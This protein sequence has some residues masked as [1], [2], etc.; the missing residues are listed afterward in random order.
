MKNKFILFLNIVTLLSFPKYN[1]GQTPDLGTT[2]GFALFTAVG[3]F[4]N[5]GTSI[6]TGD[7][8]SNTYTPTGFPVPGTVVGNIYHAGDAVSIQA[9]TDVNN[10]YG[11]LSTLGGT[12][13]GVTI[14][15]NQV[16]TP[17]VWST[18][19]ASTLNGTVIIDGMG[20]P[21]SLFIIR[22][23]GAFATGNSSNIV[24]I[25]SASICN[26]YWQ[27]NGEFNLGNSSVFRGTVIANGA[28][29]LLENSTLFGRALSKGGA[30]SLNN[31]IVNL[32]AQTILS[33][34]Y[35]NGLTSI[36]SGDSIVLSGNNGGIWSTGAT[37]PTIT[38]S[39]SGDYYLI[40]SNACGNVTSNHILVSVNPLPTI[41]AISASG[42]SV[43]CIGDSVILSGNN[44][45]IW[46]NGASTP[47]ITVNTNGDYFVTN[48]NACGS[49]TSNHITVSINPIPIATLIQANCI[50]STAT[51][52]FT[53]PIGSGISYSINDL[54]YFNTTGVFNLVSSGVYHLSAKY[55]GGC[56]SSGADVI[57][58]AR[59]VTPSA[60]SVSVLQPTCTLATG[61]AVLGGLPIGNWTINPGLIMG[62]TSSFTI[63]VLSALTISNYTVT[64]SD[65][66]T[67][68]PTENIIINAQPLSPIVS[69]TNPNAVF[70]PT[71]VNLTATAITIG[72]TPGLTYSYWKDALATLPYESPLTAIAGIYY[73]KG[74]TIAG[75]FAI[76]PVTV[77]INPEIGSGCDSIVYVANNYDNGIG[78]LR[79]AIANVCNNGTVFF[80]S[81]IDGQTINLTSGTLVIDKNIKFDN[82]NHIS[83]I[84]ISGI[85][86]NLTI[87]TGN[88]LTL[89]SG[90]K[91]TVT[92]VITSH[93][94]ISGLLIVSGA[95]F[96]YYLCELP[97]T[98]Q[99]LLTS[100]WH[101]FGSPF[102]PNMGA[103]LSNITSSVGSTQLKP[104]IN[105]VN[106]SNNITSPYYF[107]QPSVGYAI[108]PSST[109]TAVLNG[110]LFCNPCNPCPCD[111]IIPLIY[112]GS[113][114]TQSWNLLSNP[115][116]SYINWNLV[117]KINVSNT[118][119]LWDNNL[120]PAMNP[121]ANSAY[122]RTYNSNTNIGV[123]AGTQSYI[124]PMQGFFVKAVY[125]NPKIMIPR[126]ARTNNSSVYYKDITTTEIL[127]RLKIETETGY[128][129]LV[130]CKNQESELNFEAFDSEKFFNNLPVEIYSQS[131]TGEKLTINTINTTN[132][133]IPVGMNG[134]EGAKAKITAFALESGEQ[135][136]LED[137]FKGKIISL[138]DQR[139]YEFEFPTNAINE[140]FFI[141]FGNI[142]APLSKSVINVFENNNQLNIIAQTGE[143]LKEVEI[144]TLT[145]KSVFNSKIANSNLFSSE[146]N[147]AQAMY[148]V[149][150]KTSLSTQNIKISWK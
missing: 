138:T 80:L 8:G 14:V 102:M 1:F 18:G 21:N 89:E 109:F 38:V 120:Y 10:L 83:G 37:T 144:F 127:L 71:T 22:I 141:H 103:S 91:I 61:S 19:A 77:I 145:G 44:G 6:I 75:C 150:V 123:P 88:T 39:T 72:S 79:N 131:T 60:P 114:A 112:N 81:A 9:A 28:I 53:S 2:S 132:T 66:C 57:I 140:R 133:V 108:K 73:I 104:Y 95:S 130:I 96:I 30:I 55:S 117:G 143:E 105:G 136:Y 97:A 99:R 24:L 25:N 126:S 121:V 48:T 34:I 148:I 135:V 46:S 124:A 125:T 63:T 36:C 111:F 5:I 134:V 3:A 76:K 85:G 149:R 118:L 50:D 128:D 68:N 106:W 31:N 12:V 29:N 92:G 15:N 16:I 7:I 20:N 137:R 98:V 52:S 13:L 87:N 119:Y 116:T 93:A 84:T 67:S 45:G 115:Y 122:L 27:I 129:E 90:S 4:D 107:L 11:Y 59:P 35:A 49:V 51:I 23:G 70:S 58:N 65:G 62:S 47:T 41:S 113:S 146:I 142:N 43:L 101:L 26:I 56:I 74:T 40:N 32:G 42:A 94:G 33:T 17:G 82:Y 64:N 86:D 100:S 139:T 147:L 54:D 110:N 78:S 69:I